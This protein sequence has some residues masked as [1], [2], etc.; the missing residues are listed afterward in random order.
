MVIVKTESDVVPGQYPTNFIVTGRSGSRRIFFWGLLSTFLCVALFFLKP[1]LLQLLDFKNYDLLLRNFPNNCKTNKVVIVD[2][3]EESLRR[4]GQ[5]PWPRYQVAELL[6]KIATMEPAVIGLDMVFA[7]PDRTSAGLLLK[8][9]G[10]AYHLN[11][12]IDQLPG[13]LSD[14][15]LI[16]AESLAKGPFVLGNKFHF[17][18][19]E[20]SSEQ[21]TLHPVKVFIQGMKK[22]EETIGIPESTGV[23]CNLPI[24][25]EKIGASGFLNFSPDQDGML[26]RLP[27]LIRHKG[28]LYPSLALAT[29]LKLKEA[30]NL[31]LKKN[32][33]ALQSINF[34]GTSV[35]VDS[36]SQLLIKFRASNRNYDYVSAAHILDGSVS[37]KQ[38]QGRIAFVGTSADGLKEFR[39]TPFDAIF[40]GVEV[41]A[42][43]ADNLL[44]GDFISIPSWSNG[45]A[46]LLVLVLGVLLSLLVAF[47]GAA[48]GFIA[49]LLFTV[50]LWMATQQV[51]FRMGMFVGTAFPMA[52]VVCNYIFLTALKYRLEEK[53]MLSGLRE[54]LLTQDITIECMANLA[55]YRDSE[56]GGHI[57]R[58]RRYVGLL[59]QH[60][61]RHDKYK[62]FLT[63]ENIEMLY[64]SNPLH[65]IGKVGIPDSIL[66]KPSQLTEEEFE[67]MK[68]HTT[69]GHDV[70]KSSIR[71]LGKKSFLTIAAEM[72]Q[73][74]QEKWDGSGYPQGLKG[75]AIPISGRLMALADVYDALISKR[76]YK[77]PFSHAMSVDT[78]EKGRGTHFDPD[79]VDAFI[80][81]HE[82]FR[83]I[84]LE[85][86]DF[87]EERET[88]NEAPP[89]G[90]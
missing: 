87:P 41:Q 74:H 59:A 63:E 73:S 39:T 84:A 24:L 29:V 4:Y 46:L 61:K 19:I 31:L 23:L 7:E 65:D 11:L 27:L 83:D 62:H 28:N 37:P 80:E 86:A 90:E 10:A 68:A 34:K 88:L 72:A 42:T 50:G 44:T 67:V 56:T 6:D 35:P 21:C 8:D 76:V 9:L 49:M 1:T 36:H 66:L 2:L 47:S 20:R 77:P 71:K 5:W 38:L 48:S 33:D 32:G 13:K 40:P 60:I 43:I 69:I 81:I 45:V 51:F 25:S 75:D 70:I 82:Q 64:K 52:S 55:E 79:L 12:T 30:N 18:R 16:L 57:K 85:F 15:D 53:K 22:N 3:D 58:T 14:N 54:L 78:I 17:N 89:T 26:R